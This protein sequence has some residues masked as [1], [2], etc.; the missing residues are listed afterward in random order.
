MTLHFKLRDPNSGA[1][2][3]VELPPASHQSP[4]LCP[5]SPRAHYTAASL[6]NDAP[7]SIYLLYVPLAHIVSY[8]LSYRLLLT[9][10][11]PRAIY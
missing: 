4:I 8:L 5:A 7:P 9:V 3:C 2:H 1:E 11:P 6:V 10:L